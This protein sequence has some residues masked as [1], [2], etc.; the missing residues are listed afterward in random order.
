MEHQTHLLH[1][2]RLLSAQK[3][4]LCS[5]NVAQ[6]SGGNCWRNLLGQFEAESDEFKIK[7]M[8]KTLAGTFDT[9]SGVASFCFCC[10]LECPVTY[11]NARGIERECARPPGMSK[12]TRRSWFWWNLF[13]YK[14]CCLQSFCKCWTELSEG[15]QVKWKRL[16]RNNLWILELDHFITTKKYIYR[17]PH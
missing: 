15:H 17:L 4:R 2:W 16:Q 1:L 6:R 9:R 7:N 12:W 13:N 3:K 10:L 11:R 14:S 8:T 5:F